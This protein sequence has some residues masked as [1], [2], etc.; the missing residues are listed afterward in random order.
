MISL[1]G[2]FLSVPLEIGIIILNMASWIMGVGMG[3]WVELLFLWKMYGGIVI[4]YE[5]CDSVMY[6]CIFK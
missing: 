5:V 4:K 6:G 3:G 1:P 2:V